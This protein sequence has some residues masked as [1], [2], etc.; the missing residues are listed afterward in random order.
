MIISYSS[1]GLP[2][3]NLYTLWLIYCPKAKSRRDA[4]VNN[5]R[6]S[7]RR[8]ELAPAIP[9]EEEEDKVLPPTLPLS[10]SVP[11]FPGGVFNSRAPLGLWTKHFDL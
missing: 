1:T 9:G 5:R 2:M 6:T 4:T 7:E 11:S 3:G 8:A 10:H